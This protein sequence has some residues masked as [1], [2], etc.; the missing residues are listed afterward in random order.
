SRLSRDRLPRRSSGISNSILCP[1]ELFRLFSLPS[2][3]SSRLLSLFSIQL[4]SRPGSV[5]NS[6]SKILLGLNLLVGPLGLENL[7]SGCNLLRQGTV[8]PGLGLFKGRQPFNA[9]LEPLVP[10]GLIDLRNRVR[11]LLGRPLRL[12]IRRNNARGVVVFK[13]LGGPNRT[14]VQAPDQFR[15]VPHSACENVVL[16]QIPQGFFSLLCGFLD[17]PKF[18][19]VL[20]CISGGFI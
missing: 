16:N 13:L 2:V 15:G 9:L 6:L 1:S 17:C 12:L 7:P 4:C 3:L 20:L 11:K 5:V 18:A 8:V 10:K 19:R 14:R